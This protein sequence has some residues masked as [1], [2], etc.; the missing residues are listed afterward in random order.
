MAEQVFES[1]DIKAEIWVVP[2]CIYLLSSYFDASA[3]YLMM[4]NGKLG[5]KQEEQ[6][7]FNPCNDHIIYIY[8]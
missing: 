4:T 1:L 2:L 7:Y 8:I 5:S 3:K 6:V